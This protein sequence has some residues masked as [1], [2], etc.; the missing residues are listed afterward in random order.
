MLP[1]IQ[2]V[3]GQEHRSEPTVLVLL[4]TRKLAEQVQEVCRRYL[5]S[6]GL[7]SV[8]LVS[9]APKDQLIEQIDQLR[10]GVDIVIAT[11]GRLND[12]IRTGACNVS[13]VSSPIDF[14][15]Y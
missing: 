12:L 13:K 11:P 1:A 3:M 14:Q 9:G 5:Q 8:C 6:A 7:D 2:H 4:P 10:R 15:S